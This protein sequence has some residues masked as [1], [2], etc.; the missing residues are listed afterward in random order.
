MTNETKL[1][2]INALLQSIGSD[3]LVILIGGSGDF[4]EIFSKIV[5]NLHKKSLNK[6]LL[7]F[8]FSY[9]LDKND[10]PLIEQYNDLKRVLQY[11]EKH[12]SYAQIEL[13]ATSQG[14]YS[15]CKVL[16]DK[17]VNTNIRKAHFVDPADY[18]LSSEKNP[19]QT[20]HTWTGSSV[21]QPT[22]KTASDLLLEIPEHIKN[23]CSISHIEKLR[24]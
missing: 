24:K 11:L 5:K 14:A 16:A 3:T 20:T 17:E 19:S 7:T 9:L 18:E 6:D 2:Q 1:P 10:L 13:M 4:K 15:V 21:Y 23:K 12:Y 8:T 22:E